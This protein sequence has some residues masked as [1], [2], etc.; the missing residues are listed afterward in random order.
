MVS[1]R[2]LFCFASSTC[3][4]NKNMYYSFPEAKTYE[5]KNFIL[6]KKTVDEDLSTVSKLL[7]NFF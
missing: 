1:F 4:I 2:Y 5:I 3:G 7:L 6:T